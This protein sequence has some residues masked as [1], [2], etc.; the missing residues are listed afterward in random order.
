MGK[1][2]CLNLFFHF[3]WMLGW[4]A[5]VIFFLL[6]IIIFPIGM[7]AADGCEFLKNT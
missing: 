1:G 7:V 2:S 5:M 6:A 4:L 3:G